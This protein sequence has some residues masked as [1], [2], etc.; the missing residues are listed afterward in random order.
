MS[1][2]SASP[3]P[4]A[5]QPSK[6]QGYKTGASIGTPVE[7]VTNTNANKGKELSKAQRKKKPLIAP[8]ASVL[9]WLLKGVTKGALRHM[10]TF[11]NHNL[12][13]K[14]VS[15]LA[16]DIIPSRN[17]QGD[18]NG[19][20]LAARLENRIPQFCTHKVKIK[21]KDN[22][23]QEF[24]IDPFGTDLEL[25]TKDPLQ[26][27][28]YYLSHG[29]L[30][31]NLYQAIKKAKPNIKLLKA[32]HKGKIL[33][34]LIFKGRLYFENEDFSNQ[35][36][37]SIKFLGNPKKSIECGLMLNTNFEKAKLQNAV[38]QNPWLFETNFRN[39]NL[40][41][42]TF[43]KPAMSQADFEGAKLQ[44]TRFRQQSIAH[45]ST[46]CKPFP[47]LWLSAKFRSASLEDSI[48]EKMCFGNLDFTGAKLNNTKLKN[49]EYQIV[50]FEG[51]DL[52]GLEFINFKRTKDKSSKLLFTAA[53]LRGTKLSD[54]QL[55]SEQDHEV[56]FNKAILSKIDLSNKDLS[57]SSFKETKLDGA[58]LV[59]TKLHK[60]DLSGADLRDA[61]LNGAD[62]RQ[63]SI[64]KAKLD[65]AK[66]LKANL[67]EHNFQTASLA[68]ADIRGAN[69]SGA[70]IG[71]QDMSAR[72]LEYV[73]VSKAMLKGTDFSSSNL[74]RVNF[75][76]AI[77]KKA[78]FSNA[79]LAKCQ[80]HDGF[81]APLLDVK[82]ANNKFNNSFIVASDLAGAHSFNKIAKEDL[83]GLIYYF[84]PK[85]KNDPLNTKFPY[86]FDVN[87]L[88]NS[89]HAS[90]KN[91]HRTYNLATA[92][93]GS[94][95]LK[96]TQINQGFIRFFA[97]KYKDLVKKLDFKKIPDNS[98]SIKLNYVD[99]DTVEFI[100]KHTDIFKEIDISTADLS[101]LNKEELSR[102][103]RLIKLCKH[104]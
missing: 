91:F 71:E 23:E 73:N 85:N 14:L 31:S 64:G 13:Y 47:S 25:E 46:H 66:L 67:T 30:N 87:K 27:A 15:K 9:S 70:Y 41:G 59:N 58:I 17:R 96:A 84:N 32:N 86:G 94:I 45:G 57:A 93:E 54:L 79:F 75:S 8:K 6:G 12:T 49:I 90:S 98:V 5:S 20:Y 38:F 51:A 65:G 33:K 40:R 103:K 44:N 76:E 69:C 88:K 74:Y 42:A 61:N 26:R 80:F 81:Y 16:P 95:P 11:F 43:I 63:S 22:I 4:T 7:P 36:M 68:E 77:L 24:L 104:L 99:Q 29:Y 78:N 53:D 97:R 52:R 35:N 1:I 83:N 19:H 56:N 62:L 60:A 82:L 28:P 48:F 101:P 100:K 3:D 55:N 89:G 39:A 10:P 102:F 2:S 37:Q 21:D 92:Q 18:L 34:P 50:N 72:D